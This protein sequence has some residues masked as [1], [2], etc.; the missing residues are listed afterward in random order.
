MAE[1]TPFPV[2]QPKEAL[3]FFRSKGLQTGFAWQDVWQEE[4][5]RAFTVAK[6]MSRDLLEDMRGAV[7][8]ALADGSTLADFQRELR[9]LLERKGWWGRKSML[10][11]ATGEQKIVQLGSPRRLKTIF[12]VNMRSAYAAGRWERAERSKAGFPFLRYV[13]AG[14]RKVR[15]EHQ[16][17]HGVVR[18]IGD[19]FWNTHYPPCGWN[20]RCTAV[21]VSNSMLGRRGWSVTED[22]PSF[23]KEA[24]TNPRTGEVTAIERGIDPGFNFNVGK[25]YFDTLAPPP[26]GGTAAPPAAGVDAFLAAFGIDPQAPDD[27]RRQNFFDKS[28]WPLAV[29]SGWFLN[30]AR[31]LVVPGK[32]PKGAGATATLGLVGNAIADPDEIRRVWIADESGTKRLTHRYLKFGADDAVLVDVGR[33]GWSFELVDKRRAFA[34]AHDGVRAWS[35]VR[36][37][38]AREYIELSLQ[39]EGIGLKTLIL[40]PIANSQLTKLARLVPG[41]DLRHL[42]LDSSNVRHAMKF[43]GKD[44]SQERALGIEDVAEADRIFNAATLSKGDPYRSREGFYRVHIDAEVDGVRYSGAFEIRRDR[45]VLQTL[46]RK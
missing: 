30:A 14:D 41:V 18:P 12:E 45:A 38:L 1:E 24:Y 3:A 31:K 25:A 17:W 7:D 34:A 13:T 21:P 22:P 16:A 40:S 33:A 46:R 37:A 42:A 5:A 15:P 8:K 19:D 20:C 32:L 44:R 11:P 28:G 2:V 29:S 43:H 39:P 36:S 27:Q 23:P 6:A 26:N 35:P 10:D 9:P 4:H